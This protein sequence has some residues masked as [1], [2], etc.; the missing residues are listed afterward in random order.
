MNR[1]LTSE[2]PQSNLNRESKIF[3]VGSIDGVKS[4]LEAAK[5]SYLRVCLIGT[6]SETVE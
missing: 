5:L 6:N 4:V 1:Y 2:C 3:L